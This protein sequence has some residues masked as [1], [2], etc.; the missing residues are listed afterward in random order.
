MEKVIGPEE[1]VVVA[2]VVE[3]VEESVV[4]WLAYVELNVV[5]SELE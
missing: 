3:M 2:F 4:A 1:F 5:V